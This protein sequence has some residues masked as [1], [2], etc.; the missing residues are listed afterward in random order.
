MVVKSRFPEYSE[1]WDKYIKNGPNLYYSNGFIMKSEDYD[2][3][4]EFL[5][6][7][8]KVY[9]EMSGIE[10]ENDLFEH[11][12]YNIEVG[13]YQRYESL[14]DVT[15]EAIKWQ[16]AIGGF[17]S[18]RLWTLWLQHHFSDERI[19]KLPY[20]KMEKNMYT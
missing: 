17:L 9:T 12:R 6:E 2:K 18:E 14:R 13:K 20:I 11:V 16:C 8:L 10:N 7:C 3:Y 15:N 5:F 19:Y 4:C 1:S